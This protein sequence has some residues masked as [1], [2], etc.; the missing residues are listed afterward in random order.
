MH[1][2]ATIL[3]TV[4]DNNID[5]YSAMDAYGPRVVIHD[6]NRGMEIATVADWAHAAAILS[7]LQNS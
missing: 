6:H 4:R 3:I 2:P 7:A 1:N 5:L